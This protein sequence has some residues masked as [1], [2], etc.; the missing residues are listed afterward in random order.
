MMSGGGI[1]PEDQEIPIVQ[2]VQ[3]GQHVNKTESAEDNYTTGVVVSCQKMSVPQHQN[4]LCHA[5][6]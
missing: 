1:N 2:V 6:C 5:G 3:G 4:K